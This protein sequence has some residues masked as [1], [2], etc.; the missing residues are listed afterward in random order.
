MP[1]LQKIRNIFL[2]HYIGAIV[3]GILA[4]HGVQTFVNLS[5]ALIWRFVEI[6][7][8]PKGPF[9]DSLYSEYRWE[10]VIYTSVD[11]LLNAAVVFV[12]MRWIYFTQYSTGAQ[13]LQEPDPERPETAES[14][15]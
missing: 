5:L 6:W 2:T 14:G 12:L 9:G 1:M 10:R 7:R 8:T 13:Q 15:A 4:A 11:L 3:I